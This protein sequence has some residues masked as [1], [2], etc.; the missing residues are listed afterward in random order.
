LFCFLMTP[1]VNIQQINFL[2]N[3]T[4]DTAIP[5]LCTLL[6]LLSICAI[7]HRRQTKILPDKYALYAGMLTALGFFTKIL[8]FPV[9]IATIGFCNTRKK[10]SYYIFSL[11]C[12]SGLFMVIIGDQIPRMLWWIKN[13]ILKNGSYGRGSATFIDPNTYFYNIFNLLYNNYLIL[14]SIIFSGFSVLFFIKKR[15]HFYKPL[16]I[17]FFVF[18]IQIIITSKDYRDYYLLSIY[19]FIPILIYLAVQLYNSKTKKILK[20]IFFVL[21]SFNIFLVFNSYL[22]FKNLMKEV[23][24]YH[25]FSENY[26]SSNFKNVLLVDSVAT[27]LW[28]SSHINALRHGAGHDGKAWR[29]LYELYPQYLYIKDGKFMNLLDREVP[30]NKIPFDR[31]IIFRLH[32]GLENE[33]KNIKNVHLSEI[34]EIEGRMR[35][36]KIQ[37]KIHTAQ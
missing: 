31:P 14:I 7:L 11:I 2:T 24:S 28:G 5:T 18:I 15:N 1:F 22:K 32:R 3:V 33:L 19:S 9:M 36:F 4:A 16:L 17:L 35:Y 6:I 30:R 23:S 10:L 27:G 34:V 21:F 26:I 25:F 13:L 37:E 29:K 8:T 20:I 12:M